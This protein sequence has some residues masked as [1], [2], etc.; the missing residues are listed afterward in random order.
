MPLLVVKK[1]ISSMFHCSFSYW[2]F[3]VLPDGSIY[4]ARPQSWDF[5]ESVVHGRQR[6]LGVLQCDSVLGLLHSILVVRCYPA[7]TLMKL[8]FELGERLAVE[9][10]AGW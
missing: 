4:D 7:A 8:I 10:G 2:L 3:I 9:F 1:T 6:I 5:F